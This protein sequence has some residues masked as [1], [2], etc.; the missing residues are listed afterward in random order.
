MKRVVCGSCNQLRH[1]YL[2]YSTNLT[3]ERCRQ[4]VDDSKLPFF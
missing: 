2:I 1:K 4:S 3:G